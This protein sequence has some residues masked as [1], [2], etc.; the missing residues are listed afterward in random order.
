MSRDLSLKKIVPYLRSYTVTKSDQAIPSAFTRDFANKKKISSEQEDADSRQDTEEQSPESQ[1]TDE[2][3][4]PEIF[5]LIENPDFCE[6]FQLSTGE[7]EKFTRFIVQKFRKERGVS[8]SLPIS[9]TNA[10][11]L[12][13]NEIYRKSIEWYYNHKNSSILFSI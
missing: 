8:E 13:K 9:C 5:K 4:T 2:S 12:N 6:L 10:L 11:N 1:K 3:N 7:K